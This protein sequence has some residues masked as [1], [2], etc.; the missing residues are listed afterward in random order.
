MVRLNESSS[1]PE[2]ATRPPV[3]H[4]GVNA[5]S[6]ENWETLSVLDRAQTLQERKLREAFYIKKSQ[7]KMNRDTGLE[8]PQTWHSIL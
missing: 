6:V 7:P 5:G 8:H 2:Q 4:T 3:D 1:Y